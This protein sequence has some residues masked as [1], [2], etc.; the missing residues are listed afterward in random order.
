LSVFRAGHEIGTAVILYGVA[1]K[2]T[3]RG[4]FP[5]LERA[6][7]HRSNLYAAE[8]PYMLRLTRDGIAIHASDVRPQGATHGCIGVPI[9]FGRRL[10]REVRKGDLVAIN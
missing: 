1:S 10:F 2:P 6:E 3:R 8:M 7:Q 5:I 9:A 4:V